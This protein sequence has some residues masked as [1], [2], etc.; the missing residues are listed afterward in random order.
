M[1][2]IKKISLKIFFSTVLLLTFF[3]CLKKKRT[4]TVKNP[5]EITSIS[6]SDIGG[7][8]GSY[9]IIR[10]TKDSIHSERG[11]AADKTHHRWDAA[12]TPETWQ[13]MVSAIDPNTLDKIKS[14]PSK[15]PV[16]GTD[17][18]FQIRT[19]KKSH[20]YVNSYVDN[21]HY[22]QF[23]KLKIRIEKILPKEYQ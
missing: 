13:N 14:S 7:S 9:R 23:Q 10:I 8:L 21:I 19:P 5:N 12:I 1:S 3:S 16:D 2:A 11:I 22:K 20:V 6:L 18:T 4:T 17:E 15:Q